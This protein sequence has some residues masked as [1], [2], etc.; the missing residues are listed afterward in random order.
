MPGACRRGVNLHSRM[1][2]GRVLRRDEEIGGRKE[3]ELREKDEERPFAR[4]NYCRS[5]VHSFARSSVRLG[6]NRYLS[7]FDGSSVSAVTNN[8]DLPSERSHQSVR[9]GARHVY[10]E[11]RVTVDGTN[12]SY[13]TGKPLHPNSLSSLSLSP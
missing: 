6:T 2:C 10:Y 8:I 1:Q 4:N 12:A 3:E 5:L 13:R 11:A 7:P 9:R